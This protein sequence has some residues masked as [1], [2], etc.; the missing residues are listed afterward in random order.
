[1][2]IILDL[3]SPTTEI[4]AFK[5]SAR[6]A[7]YPRGRTLP[8]IVVLTFKIARVE[9]PFNQRDWFRDGS[10]SHE[11]LWLPTAYPATTT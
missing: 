10:E 7:F 4:T 5:A 8:D 2:H 1:M 6:N 11:T 9:C 3:L